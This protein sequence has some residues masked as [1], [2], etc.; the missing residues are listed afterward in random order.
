MALSKRSDT[1]PVAK[2]LG[3]NY[4]ELGKYIAALGAGTAGKKGAAAA[5]IGDA[6]CGE[7]QSSGVFG[8]DAKPPGRYAVHCI[9]LAANQPLD[10]V[11]LD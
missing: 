10:P 6:R 3:L 5:V 7:C 9:Y 1:S 8:R 11:A 2:K 4:C